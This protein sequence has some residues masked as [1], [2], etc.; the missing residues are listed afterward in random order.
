MSM[1]K[2]LPAVV[3]AGFALGLSGA[4]AQNVDS[5]KDKAKGQEQIMQEKEGATQSQPSQTQSQQSPSGE[6][7]GS[8]STKRS[9]GQTQAGQASMRSRHYS[10]MRER[11][12]TLTGD[13]RDQCLSNAR[14]QYLTSATA[15][16]ERLTDASMKQNCFND[17][18]SAV[19]LPTTGP[20]TS[21]TDAASIGTQDNQADTV[22]RGSDEDKPGRQ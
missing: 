16:C 6:T 22:K 20:A 15:R 9:D 8:S 14:S 1:S 10:Q 19:G 11:C 7:Q 5:D 13:S 4:V 2:L 3:A 21:S 12:S 17:I 18:Q